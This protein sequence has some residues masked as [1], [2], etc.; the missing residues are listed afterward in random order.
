[1]AFNATVKRTRSKTPETKNTEN[2]VYDARQRLNEKKKLKNGDDKKTKESSER[3]SRSFSKRSNEK[4]KS[5]SPAKKSEENTN[6]YGYRKRTIN[7]RSSRE[8]SDSP[9]FDVNKREIDLK[10]IDL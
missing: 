1:M 7:L 10:K 4:D 5:P 3:I 2:K 9:E 8:K 6:A